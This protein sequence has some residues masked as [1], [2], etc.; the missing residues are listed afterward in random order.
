[1][2]TLSPTTHPPLVRY[3]TLGLAVWV[4]ATAA[5]RMAPLGALRVG[6]VGGGLAILA[7]LGAVVGLAGLLVR[8]VARDQRIAAMSAFVLPGMVGDSVTTGFC[9][10]VFPNLP[11]GS[12]GIFGSLM[13][14]GYAAM[15]AVS[16]IRSIEPKSA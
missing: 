1:M 12:G 13:L 6:P 15:L 14:A 16:V 8:D 9:A 11:V 5:I 7:G 4:L 10:T 2:N 3:A